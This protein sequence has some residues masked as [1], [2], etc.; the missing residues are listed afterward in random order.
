MNKL[1]FYIILLLLIG[2]NTSENSDREE[3]LKYKERALNLKELELKRIQDSLSQ[4]NPEPSST[5]KF[6]YV[7]VHTKEL[8]SGDSGLI[9]SNYQYTS[10]IIQIPDFTEDKKY[11]EIDKYKD[12][13]NVKISKGNKILNMMKDL[14]RKDNK[15]MWYD[16]FRPEVTGVEFFVFPSFKEAS[17]S[18]NS[19]TSPNLVLSSEKSSSFDYVTNI[20]SILKNNSLNRWSVNRMEISQTGNLTFYCTMGEFS[21]NLND[22]L[23]ITVPGVNEKTRAPNLGMFTFPKGY[24]VQCNTGETGLGEECGITHITGNDGH[25]Y[26]V[27]PALFHNFSELNTQ[28][29]LELVRNLKELKKEVNNSNN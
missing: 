11:M 28:N 29:F 13:V 15:P 6:L 27:W 17:I 12:L 5:T 23:D 7:V 8:N 1:F 16:S 18:R 20:N 26:T 21:F 25:E 3:E 19:I 22:V 2:C 4:S 9:I 14:D 10:K 24:K